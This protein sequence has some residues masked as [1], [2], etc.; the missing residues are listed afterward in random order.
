MYQAVSI[1]LF[2]MRRAAK[3]EQPK[4]APKVEKAIHDVVSTL[5]PESATPVETDSSTPKEIEL[6]DEILA[7]LNEDWMTV[8]EV[9]DELP[10]DVQMVSPQDSVQEALDEYTALGVI[11]NRVEGDIV[12]YSSRSGSVNLED[13]P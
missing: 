13:V 7:V 4:V 1:E 10:A 3:L 8:E 2:D 12:E 11:S 9:Y 5:D 6:E